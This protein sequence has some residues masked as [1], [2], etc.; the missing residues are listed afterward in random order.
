MLRSPRSQ[1]W[2]KARHR[3]GVRLVPS[4]GVPYFLKACGLILSKMFLSA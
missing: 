3:V 2:D 1:R 4:Q